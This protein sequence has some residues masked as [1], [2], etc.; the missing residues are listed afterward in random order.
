MIL[1]IG[2]KTPENARKPDVFDCF[3]A[4]CITAIGATGLA[5]ACMVSTSIF[6][7]LALAIEKKEGRGL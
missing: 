3:N 5:V 6:A 1:P 7:A 4:A 2:N